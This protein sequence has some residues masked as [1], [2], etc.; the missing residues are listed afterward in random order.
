MQPIYQNRQMNYQQGE[1]DDEEIEVIEIYERDRYEPNELYPSNINFILPGK[2]YSNFSAQNQLSFNQQNI[3]SCTCG[4]QH[5]YQNDSQ[6]IPSSPYAGRMNINNENLSNNIQ[7]IGSNIIYKDNNRLYSHRNENID[8]FRISNDINQIQ[9]QNK[10]MNQVP[11]IET[12]N[13]NYL[14]NNK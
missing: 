9:N 14:N 12:Q 10:I 3:V 7:N 4:K 13:N 2:S 6:Y 11:Q 5:F 8:K 1:S